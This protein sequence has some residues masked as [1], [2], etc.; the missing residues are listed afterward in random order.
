[1]C[2]CLTADGSAPPPIHCRGKDAPSMAVRKP[3]LQTACMFFVVWGHCFP[4]I[5]KVNESRVRITNVC[6]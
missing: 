5:H 4:F 3:P 2:L 6:D 1:M